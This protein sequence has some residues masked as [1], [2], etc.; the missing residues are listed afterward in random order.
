M[1]QELL[2]ELQG[3]A[4]AAWAKEPRRLVVYEVLQ[5]EMMRYERIFWVV[6]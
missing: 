3:G 1:S 6:V 2:L 5:D 4:S